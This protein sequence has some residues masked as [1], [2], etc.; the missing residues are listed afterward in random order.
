[1]YK[2]YYSSWKRIP[3]WPRN[4]KSFAQNLKYMYQRGK[5]GFADCDVWSLDQYLIEIIANSVRKLSETCHGYPGIGDYDTYGKWIDELDLV[6]SHFAKALEENEYFNTPEEDK[7]HQWIEDTV[8]QH[9]DI[10][11]LEYPDFHK[12]M[13]ES[14]SN[15]EKRREE[16]KKGFKLLQKVFPYLWD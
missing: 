3:N 10:M 14:K 15:D 1:M 9:K 12:V 8:K 13:E 6:A 16:L 2:P 7:Y 5:R 11:G 4:I